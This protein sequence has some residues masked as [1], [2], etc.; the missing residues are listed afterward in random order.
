M[1]L[2]ELARMFNAEYGLGARLT[3]VPMPAYRREW[4]YDQTGLAW[5]APSPNLRTLDAAILYPGVALV[6]GANVSVGRGTAEP[7]ALVGAPWVDAGDLAR[8]LEARAIPGVRFEA[9][10]FSPTADR[11]AR[12][13]CH[14]VR[15]RLL[16]RARLDAPR[17]GMELAAALHWLYPADF[18]LGQTAGLIGSTSTLAAIEHGAD[19][20]TLP[21]GWHAELEKFKVLRAKYVL[22]P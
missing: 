12:Q 3:V 14:G 22:Y 2:G 16:D 21:A 20:R 6:E 17:L 13:P 5:T 19:P 7:F 1:T 8:Y 18:R 15:I 4:W 11:Y 9:A 10:D